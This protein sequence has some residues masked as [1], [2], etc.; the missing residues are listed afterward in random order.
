L[1]SGMLKEDSTMFERVGQS[2]KPVLLIWGTKDP[3]INVRGSK[4]FIDLVPQAQF[5]AINGAG[6]IPHF[7]QPEKVNPMLT[8]F[9]TLN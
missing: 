2:R 5:I 1:R 8:E 7:E 4:E 6:H 3:T 9:L